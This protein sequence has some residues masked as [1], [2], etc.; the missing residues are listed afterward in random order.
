MIGSLRRLLLFILFL[1]LSML[2]PVGL[3][4]AQTPGQP[5]LKKAEELIRSGRAEEAWKLLSPHEFDLAGREDFDYLLGV[6]ALDSGRADRATLVFERVLAINPEHAAA[7]LDMARAYFALG[8]YQR[9]RGEFEQVML[10]DDTPPAAKQTIERYLSAIEERA[11]SQ[12]TR[13]SGYVEASIGRDSN[14]NSATASSS[15]YVPL[16]NTSFTLGSSSVKA[17]D[18]FFSAGGGAE[19]THAIAAGMNLFAGVDAKQR[20]HRNWDVY[21]NRSVDYRAGLQLTHNKDTARIS[22]GRNDYELDNERY[23]RIGSFGIE[24]RHAADAQTQYLGFAQVSEIKYL[25]DGTAS[26]SSTQTIAGAGMV[27]SLGGSGNPIVFGSLFA[28]DDM[29]TR[30]RG[31]GDRYI[32][33][34]RAGY[35][36]SLRD[37]LDAYATLSMQYSDYKRFNPLFQEFRKETQYDLALGLNWRMEHDWALKPLLTYTRSDSNFQVYDFDRLE[38]SLTLRKDFR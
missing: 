1:A 14:L 6:A 37:R 26:Y 25:Q 20:V 2:L 29:A 31:D 10:N 35:Q 27:K 9:S 19:L 12:R 32:F 4:Q 24:V 8:D 33:G 38:L 30:R 23:R 28:G 5:D 21:D 15:I 16:F 36:R 3:A 22:L 11:P 7:R 17:A 18:N 34:L 13:L